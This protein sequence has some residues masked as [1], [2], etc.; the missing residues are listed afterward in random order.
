VTNLH[1]EERRGR[2]LGIYTMMMALGLMLGPLLGGALVAI[3]D[4]PAVF[5]FRIP[6]A[7]A[8]LMLSGGLPAAQPREAREPF[9]I[10]GGI[11]LTLGLVTLL[12]ALNRIREI[13]A[14]WLALS[15]AAAFVAVGCRALRC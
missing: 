2:A 12:L 8:A 3:W 13:S 11:A 10:A 15:S 4:W 1:G 7:I 6:I 9:D 5:W 14:I